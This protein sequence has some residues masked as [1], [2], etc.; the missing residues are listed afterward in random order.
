[1]RQMFSPRFGR[2][3]GCGHDPRFDAYKGVP[4]GRPREVGRSSDE[5]IFI[6]YA[7]LLIT[8]TFAPFDLEW[9]YVVKASFVYDC[10]NLLVF[11][12]SNLVESWYCK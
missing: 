2:R 10:E 6:Y 9:T 5:V 8:K 7:T 11:V 12:S 4:V 1:M 3:C